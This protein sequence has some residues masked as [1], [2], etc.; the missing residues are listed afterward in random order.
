VINKSTCSQEISISRDRVGINKM[1][2]LNLANRDYLKITCKS[3]GRSDMVKISGK[4]YAI[5]Y[6]CPNCG[7][8]DTILNIEKYYNK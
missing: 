5:S 6:S 1:T 4:H 3:C 7:F 8:V 2:K